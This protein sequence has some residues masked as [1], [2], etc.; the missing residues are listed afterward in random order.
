MHVGILVLAV[1][2]ASAASADAADATR[3]REIA[4]AQ[5]RGNCLACHRIPSDPTAETSANLGPVLK[6]LSA[7][8]PDRDALRRQV[9]DASFANPDS[10][11]PPYGRHRI[12]TEVEIDD[13]VEY[14]WGQ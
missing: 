6:G 3:G 12:L 5:E 4:Q 7:R 11:M 8:F 10:I 9:W 13:V 2:G 1:L 14:L